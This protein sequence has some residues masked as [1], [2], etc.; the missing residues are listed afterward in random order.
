MA[1]DL[2]EALVGLGV[3]ARDEERGDRGELAARVAAAVDEALDAAD[4]GLGDLAVALEREDQRDVDRDARGDRVL[5]RLQALDRR[6]DLDEE[7]RAVDQLVQAL[8]LGLGGLGVVREVRVDLERDPAV[9]A[10]CPR[11]RRGA[12][13]RRR[14]GCRPWRAAR[15]SPW[16]RRA[17]RSARGSDRRRRRPRRSRPGRS[18]GW[19]SR[20][21]RPARRSPLRSPSLTNVRDR[22]SIQTLWSCS[23]SCW[24][25]VMSWVLSEGSSHNDTPQVRPRANE[26]ES[27]DAAARAA[28]RA[29]RGRVAIS[30]SQAATACSSRLASR[31]RAARAWE[32]VMVFGS[33]GRTKRLVGVTGV[34]PE[35]GC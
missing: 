33:V 23:A 25:G 26:G 32:A 27:G 13:C 6:R 12:G 2:V 30:R 9:L 4:V 18:S 21:R 10:A 11:P 20:R 29:Q 15:R 31:R 8:G 35:R 17:R 16:D 14:R 19:T 34:L 3:H 1:A 22:K 7:V 24:R 5:D 28:S